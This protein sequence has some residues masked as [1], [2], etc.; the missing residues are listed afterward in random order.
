M[1]LDDYLFAKRFLAHATDGE[2]SPEEW[3]A[4]VE[5]LGEHARLM[6]MDDAAWHQHLDDVAQQ[7]DTMLRTK[8]PQHVVEH[9]RTCIGNLQAAYQDKEGALER[10][11]TEFRRL[12]DADGQ[13]HPMEEHFLDEIARRWQQQ[14]ATPKRI[15]A[16]APP[17][18]AIARLRPYLFCKLYMAHAADGHFTPDEAQ[19]I[20]DTV[21]RHGARIGLGAKARARLMEETRD[22]YR[23]LHDL[24]HHA[25]RDRFLGALYD[26]RAHFRHEPDVLLS[27]VDEMHQLA[28]ADGRIDDE[29]SQIL[30]EVATSWQPGTDPV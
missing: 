15:E 16:V 24:G 10:L 18:G 30:V 22:E 14:L 13:I 26:V 3:E 9:F 8:G 27:L 12:A 23:T 2:L 28:A 17:A 1:K 19:S 25:L 4:I 11:L 20:R 5:D 21:A 7:Y 6:G 29:E